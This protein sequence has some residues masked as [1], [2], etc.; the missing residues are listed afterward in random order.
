MTDDEQRII[1]A[2][3]ATLWRLDGLDLRPV[4]VPVHVP[5][6]LERYRAEAREQERRQ[7]A[8]TRRRRQKERQDMTQANDE[9]WTAIDARIA[10]A[11]KVEHERVNALLHEQDKVHK[12]VLNLIDK[13]LRTLEQHRDETVRVTDNLITRMTALADGGPDGTGVIRKQSI[14]PH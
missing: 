13:S 4:A 1:D 6:A 2:A 9:F 7:R 11:V 10:Q 8:E 14:T 12:A 5:D 3:R